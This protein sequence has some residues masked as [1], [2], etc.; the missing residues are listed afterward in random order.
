MMAGACAASM[1]ARMGVALLGGWLAA[2]TAYLLVLTVAAVFGSR[3]VP[4]DGPARRRFA[5]LVPAHDEEALLPRLLA[6]VRAVDYPSDRLDVYVVADNCTD[7]TA[8]VAR[9]G[10]ARVDE[11]VDEV[12]RGKGY[13]LRW[14]LAQIGAAG[15]RYD[16]FVVVDADSV[17]ARDFFRRM[18]A[19]LEAGSQVVQAYY[20]VLNVGESPLAAL[21]FA[22]L[23]ALHYLRPLGRAALSLSCGLKGNGMCFAAPVLEQFGWSWFTLAEDVEF[24]LALVRAGIRVDFAH[25]TTV[26]AD[27]PVT[28]EQ[29]ESQNRRWEQGR[30]EM[31]RAYGPGL[32]ADAVR[33]RSFLRLDAVIEQL[34]PP[35]SVPFALAGALLLAGGL[36]RRPLPALVGLFGLGGQV[37]YLLAGL[38]LVRAPARAYRALA[39]APVYVAWKVALYGRALGARGAAPWV[40]TSRTPLGRDEEPSATGRDGR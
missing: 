36:L 18:D 35:L 40:R 31:L 13:A 15:E 6:S 27:M 11:R 2:T 1:L 21:R 30:V 12:E 24:H 37:A 39:Y 34:I 3:R 20:T 38:Q 17:V 23:A 9:A 5:L 8:D 7:R 22:A 26:L 32:V 16:A 14:L 4:P 29:A 10:G 33:D 28:F 25:E 19:R